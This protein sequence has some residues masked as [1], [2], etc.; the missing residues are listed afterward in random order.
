MRNGSPISGKLFISTRPEG[1]S[2]DLHHFFNHRGARLIEMPTIKIVSAN[3][4]EKAIELIR[5]NDTFDWIV[6]TSSNGII[7]FFKQLKELTGSCK[8]A[9]DTKIAV[10]GKITGDTLNNYSY[11]P[12]YTSQIST[13]SSFAEELKNLFYGKAYRILLPLGNLAGTV[14]ES[15]LKEVAEVH[16]TNVYNT[17]MPDTFNQEALK[18]IEE[19][20]YEMII[21][22]SS[23]GFINFHKIVHE[24]TDIKSIRAVCIGKITARTMEKYGISPLITAQEMSSQGIAEAILDYYG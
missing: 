17:E 7:H 19:K 18:I 1:K 5:K 22:T 15:R 6:F 11:Q 14:I 3:L 12:H 8:I 16:R 4:N 2:G 23:S 13:G 20:N 24:K 10:I 9:G 21:F